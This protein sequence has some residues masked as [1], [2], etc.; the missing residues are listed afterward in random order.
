MKCAFC[1]GELLNG[2][3]VLTFQMSENRIIGVKNVPALICEQCGEESVD[4]KG[5]QIVE[6]NVKNAVS[7]GMVMGFIDYN[8]AA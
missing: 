8:D 4:F 3:T 1:K 2:K 6:K 5:S 7:D